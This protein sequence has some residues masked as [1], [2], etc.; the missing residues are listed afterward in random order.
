MILEKNFAYLEYAVLSK[1]LTTIHKG[2]LYSLI[3]HKYNFGKVQWLK[4][5]K[6]IFSFTVLVIYLVIVLSGQEKAI[7][8]TAKKGV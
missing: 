1:Y 7:S 5:K 3:I 6:T 2:N 8:L 4:K